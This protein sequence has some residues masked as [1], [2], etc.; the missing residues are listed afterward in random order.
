MGWNIWWTYAEY[1]A[2]KAEHVSLVPENISFNEAAS[3]VVG[4][5]TS[6]SFLIENGN[7]KAGDRIL[8]QGAA[9][10]TGAVMLQMA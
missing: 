9:G 7:V 10:G 4:I 6:Y 2:L 1:A 5:V 3:L 8:I